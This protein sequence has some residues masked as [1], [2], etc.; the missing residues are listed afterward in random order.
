LD[1]LKV[2]FIQPPA[3]LYADKRSATFIGPA[4]EL[5]ELIEE[6]RP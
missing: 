2:K 4:G 5:T 3:K 6:P 1:G